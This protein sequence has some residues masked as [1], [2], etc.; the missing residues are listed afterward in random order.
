MDIHELRVGLCSAPA[1]WVCNC[2][3][4]ILILVIYGCLNIQLCLCVEGKFVCVPVYKCW[5]LKL[6]RQQYV[7]A[8]VALGVSLYHCMHTPIRLLCECE[9]KCKLL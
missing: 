4:S 5:D 1:T 6:P 9:G 2:A 7:H 3:T 8:N